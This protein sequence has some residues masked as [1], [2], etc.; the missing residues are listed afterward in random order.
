MIKES[1]RIVNKI[2]RLQYYYNIQYCQTLQLGEFWWKIARK[3]IVVQKPIKS[4]QQ[5]DTIKTCTK[6]QFGDAYSRGFRIKDMLKIGF[7]TYK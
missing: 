6:G 1:T 5:A 4:C 2:K 3:I 7:K